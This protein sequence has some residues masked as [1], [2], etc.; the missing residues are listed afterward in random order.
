MTCP[1]KN[2]TNRNFIIA[3]LLGAFALALGCGDSSGVGGAATSL[4]EAMCAHGDACPNLYAEAD[5]VSVCEQAM[6]V[7]DDLGGTCPA[8]LD[9]VVSCHAKLS[10]DD[11][12]ARTFN[13]SHIDECTSLEQAAN[14]CEPGPVVDP[15]DNSNPDQIY[16]SC[17]GFCESA[18]NCGIVFES[19]CLTACVDAFEPAQAQSS[20][21]AQTFVD[22]FD[23]YASMTCGELVDRVNDV[24][25]VDSCTAVDNDA[26]RV[27]Q[28]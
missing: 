10:C 24:S 9:N 23:C 3:T 20:A 25:R 13:S 19:D 14:R 11:L 12:T 17:G 22:S 26:A 5:C 28:L 1:D 16:L 2:Q 7:A 15:T 18:T 6:A 21:C 27:C 4:C 8:A